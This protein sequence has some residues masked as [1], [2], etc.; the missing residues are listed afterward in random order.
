MNLRSIGGKNQI[1]TPEIP[2]WK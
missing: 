2:L 1:R